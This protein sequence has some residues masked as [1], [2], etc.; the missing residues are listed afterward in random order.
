MKFTFFWDGP[1]SQ[2]SLS[3]FMDVEGIVYCTAEQ[4]MSGQ[5]A[6][7]FNDKETYAKI[8]STVNPKEQKALGR[9]VR[10]FN[11]KI[12]N[13]LSTAIV[14][15]ASILKFSQNKKHLDKLLATGDS[16]LVEA[17]PYDKIWGIA[18]KENDPRALDMAQWQGENR[19]GFILTRTRDIIR[20]ELK[21]P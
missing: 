19:L 18:L 16:I 17:S 3:P 14:Y 11:E 2:W 21:N 10:N 15:D 8:M 6:L 4:Y 9:Q 20:A 12:W 13:T 7:L 5:K 1:F